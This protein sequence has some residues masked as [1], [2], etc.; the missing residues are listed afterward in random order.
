VGLVSAVEAAEGIA[1][2]YGVTIEAWQAP[3][4][5]HMPH[6]QDGLVHWECVLTP[7]GGP[8]LAMF[9]SLGEDLG[10][11]PPTAAQALSLA[12]AD[13]GL[14][15]SLDGFEAFAAAIGADEGDAAAE[16]AWTE[17]GRL[18]ESLEASFPNGLEGPSDGAP[19]I[20]GPSGP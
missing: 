12:L 8:S 16:A 1:L 4:N 13:I 11:G 17:L 5:P 18:D 19:E 2:A 10:D 15:R 20:S 3:A 14:Y 6:D 7:E 9:V